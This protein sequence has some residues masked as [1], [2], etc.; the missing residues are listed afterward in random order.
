MKSNQKAVLSEDK[1][2]YSAVVGG[3]VALMLT[4]IIGILVYWTIVG[5]IDLPNDTANTTRDT[6]NSTATTV[7]TLM[8]IIGIV[9]IG[10]IMIAVITGMGG[11]KR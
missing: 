6:V 1:K 11:K 4:I 2:G 8:A 5:S 10:G 7:F 9:V 3:L